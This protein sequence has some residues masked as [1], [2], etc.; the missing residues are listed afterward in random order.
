MIEIYLDILDE[1]Y[2]EVKEAFSGLADENVWKRPADGL[3]SVGELAGHIAYWE[4]MRLASEGG[5]STPYLAKCRVTSPLIDHRF[6]YYLTTI[7][8][9]PSEEHL[10]MTAEQVCSELL[11]VHTESVAY[12]KALN[13][14]LDGCPPGYPSNDTY[15][16]FLQYAAFHIAYHT[17]QM[18]TARHLLGEVTPDN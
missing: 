12:F 2:F 3:L 1:G 10:G 9:P 18:Y 5:D 14:D 11:R 7:A 13:P 8:T 4:A 15:R 17:G 16:H 6:R